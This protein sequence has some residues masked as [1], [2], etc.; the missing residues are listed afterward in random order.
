MDEKGGED[1]TWIK[2]INILKHLCYANRTQK[3]KE[4]CDFKY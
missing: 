1:K 2:I 4:L 3:P